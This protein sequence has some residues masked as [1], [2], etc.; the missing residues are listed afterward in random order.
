MLKD[1][2]QI[3]S[4]G[5]S[6]NN[7]WTCEKQDDGA[8]AVYQAGNHYTYKASTIEQWLKDNWYVILDEPEKKEV[9]NPATELMKEI[10]E[11]VLKH[12]LNYQ[13]TYTHGEDREYLIRYNDQTYEAH[14][15][16]GALKIVELIGELEEF[17]C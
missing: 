6:E 4:T 15:E 2:F 9:I 11:A 12:K 1:K 8:Y 10:Y 5:Y 17:A 13:F 16:A 3:K 14:D 7:V